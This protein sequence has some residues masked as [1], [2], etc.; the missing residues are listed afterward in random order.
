MVLV[1]N[2]LG[3]E[4][5]FEGANLKHGEEKN[6]NIKDFKIGK[7]VLVPV[8]SGDTADMIDDYLDQNA[9]TVRKSL[10]EDDLE[11]ET[12][13]RLLKLEKNEKNRKTVIQEIEKKME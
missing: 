13:E 5:E 6:V 8:D 11:Q 7:I 9:R 3:E 4:V 12:L 1:K 10:R 2:N